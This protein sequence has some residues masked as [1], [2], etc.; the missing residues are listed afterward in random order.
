MLKTEFSFKALPFYSNH[1]LY[2][3]SWPSHSEPYQSE[4]QLAVGPKWKISD[5]GIY[6]IKTTRKLELLCD[7]QKL[8]VRLLY[9]WTLTIFYIF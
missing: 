4:Q 8:L 7:D 6:R 2:V 9:S 3:S 5:V 1:F